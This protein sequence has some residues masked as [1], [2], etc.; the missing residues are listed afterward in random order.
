VP[1]SLTRTAVLARDGAESI[2][3][4]RVVL[5]LPRKPVTTVTGFLAALAP[6]HRRLIPRRFVQRRA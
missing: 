3:E 2:L 5:P 1:N 6:V 4:R